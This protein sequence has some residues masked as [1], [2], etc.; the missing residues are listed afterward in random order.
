MYD[1]S[2]RGNSCARESPESGKIAQTP[3]NLPVLSK[4]TELTLLSKLF[5]V[6]LF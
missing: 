1:I 4:I 3:E 6:I 5:D 2:Y